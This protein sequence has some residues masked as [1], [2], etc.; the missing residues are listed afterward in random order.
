VKSTALV[1][2][3]RRALKGLGSVSG[4][5][6]LVG[7]S[8]GA[9]SVA[10][11]DA[12]WLLSR[13]AGFVVAAAHLDHGL[14]PDSTE[15]AAFCRTLCESL[16]IPLRVGQA[17]VRERA[18]LGGGGIEEAAR[19]ER[20]AFL[21]AVKDERG[22]LVIA[23]A[24]TGDDQA[25]TFLLRLLR[26][27]GRAGLRCM[28]V[29]DRDLWRPL[30]GVGRRQV[31]D[32][33]RRRGQA[34]R[35]DPTNAD[36]GFLRNRVRH[37]LI[38]YLEAHF[39]PRIRWT[40]GAT[41]GQLGDESEWLEAQAEA[42][43]VEAVRREGRKVVVSRPALEG[44]PRPLARLV[45]RRALREAGG[46]AGI[47]FVHV[48]KILEI[49]SSRDPSGRRF[50]LPGRREAVVS[51]DDIRIGPRSEGAPGFAYPLPVPGRVELPG[52]LILTATPA[53]GP[54]ARTAEAAVIEMPG[55]G[56]VVRTRLPGDRIRA[57]GHEV[58]L[59]RVLRQERIPV[60][61]RA[62]LP[63]VASGS[64]ILWFPDPHPFS[65]IRG[66]LEGADAVV[67]LPARGHSDAVPGKSENEPRFVRV[68]IERS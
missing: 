61:L 7:L 23:L 20:H 40:L 35:E 38:P 18:R 29:H 44:V 62:G 67:S 15:D 45:L 26:G 17:D 22:A 21:R 63:L 54:E 57:G 9:D 51:F 30:L 13:E 42:L 32:H 8:G 4:E 16:G 52:G 43:F 46:L 12:L 5:T 27:S 55:E 10:L 31:L 58:S 64:R 24:H 28:Q 56:L 34:W 68:S 33:L 53:S 48:E 49:A 41:A 14:R 11:L 60:D 2:A 50:A 19:L 66:T 37:E 6:I 3:T 65:A 25:E 36:L 1:A 39:N 47:G 59:K